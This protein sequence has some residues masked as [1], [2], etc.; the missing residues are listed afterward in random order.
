MSTT[1]IHQSVRGWLPSHRSFLAAHPAMLP[2]Q[3]PVQMEIHHLRP[4]HLLSNEQIQS[5]LSAHDAGMVSNH[6]LLSGLGMYGSVR[7]GDSAAAVQADRRDATAIA[8]ESMAGR[9]MRYGDPHLNEPPQ[10]PRWQQEVD[11]KARDAKLDRLSYVLMDQAEDN[12]ELDRSSIDPDTYAELV[13]RMH[14]W[15]V[16]LRRALRENNRREILRCQFMLMGFANR[17]YTQSAQ[18]LNDFVIGPAPV[19]A[20]GREVPPQV[21]G[22][23]ADWS[24]ASSRPSR[25]IRITTESHDGRNDPGSA[26]SRSADIFVEQVPSSGSG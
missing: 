2:T 14:R 6:G 7:L 5:L 17:T 26:D 9:R 18:S 3:P 1:D 16:E 13:I 12:L 4:I 10:T 25:L 20:I 23:P 21:T 8:L 22:Q 11:A 15:L 19:E 24:Q